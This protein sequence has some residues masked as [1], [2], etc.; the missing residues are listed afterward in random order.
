MVIEHS[1][2]ERGN[3]LPPHRLFFPISSKGSLYAPSHR[4][5]STYHGLCYTSR[6][7]LAGT[8]NS[9]MGPPHEVSTR[10]PIALWA[11]APTTELHIATSKKLLQSCSFNLIAWYLKQRDLKIIWITI[12]RIRKMLFSLRD[13][14]GYRKVYGV[15]KMEDPSCWISKLKICL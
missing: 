12:Q 4:H 3:P 13:W 15:T 7:V 8:I 1:D 11:N 6:G 9:S 2:S 14:W 5:D 10:R